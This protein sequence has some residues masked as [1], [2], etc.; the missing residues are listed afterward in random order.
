MKREKKYKKYDRF[1]MLVRMSKLLSPVC[2]GAF[3][4]CC[5]MAVLLGMVALIVLFVNVPTEE[6]MLPPFMHSITDGSGNITGYN[7]MV[8][9]GIRMYADYADVELSDIKT[10]IYAGIMLAEAVLLIAA[11]IFRFMSQLLKNVSIKRPLEPNNAKLISF[12]GLVVAVGN[13]FI[14]FVSRFYNYFLVKTFVTDG[15]NM[16]LSLGF[17]A[18]GMIYGLLIMFIGLLYA[19]AAKQYAELC[20]PTKEMTQNTEPENGNKTGHSIVNK[21]E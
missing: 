5:F 21:S 8:G 18:G 1:G 15:R 10:V 19:Y 12:I 14:M 4:V 9:N 7:I 17:D 3:Y 11:P 2:T 20:P 6:M 13:T 16:E